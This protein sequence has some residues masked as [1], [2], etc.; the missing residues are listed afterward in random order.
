M[1][2]RRYSISFQQAQKLAIKKL[3]ANA[4]CM[5][6]VAG[7]G[8][9]RISVLDEGWEKHFGYLPVVQ[10]YGSSNKLLSWQEP[11]QS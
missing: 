10:K 8:L 11:H 9:W 5:H 7:G 2:L 3:L 4:S 6:V 1:I